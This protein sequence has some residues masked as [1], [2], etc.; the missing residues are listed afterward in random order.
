[1]RTE[2]GRVP[3]IA[4]E[5]HAGNMPLGDLADLMAFHCIDDIATKQSLLASTPSPTRVRRTINAVAEIVT[6]GFVWR[7]LAGWG[8]PSVN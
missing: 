3:G 4:S 1:M 2:L 7:P 8:K 5:L 6:P